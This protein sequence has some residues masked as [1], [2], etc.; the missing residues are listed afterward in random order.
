MPSASKSIAKRQ[1]AVFYVQAKPDWAVVDRATFTYWI[2]QM[3][4]W[5]V[6]LTRLNVQTA[7]A[8]VVFCDIQIVKLVPSIIRN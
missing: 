4:L 1:R 6:A 5:P 7:R 2:G 8:I 3:G